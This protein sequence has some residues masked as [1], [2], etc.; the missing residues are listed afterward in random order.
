[1]I[2]S[3]YHNKKTYEDQKT[4][5]VFET[6]L[7][8][9]DELFWGVLRSACFDNDNLP[10]VAGQIEDYEFWPHW[11]PT[12][13]TNSTLVEPDVFIQFQSFDLIIEAKYG[14]QGG[15]YY[16]QWENEI[17]AYRNEYGDEKPVYFL[18]VGGNAD[19]ASAS[20]KVRKNVIVNKCTWL[21]LLIQITRLRDEY[22]A[23]SMISNTHSAVIRLL[24]LIELAFNVH[25][26]YNI[27]WF[28][29]IATSKPSFHPIQYRRL[30][31][32]SNEQGTG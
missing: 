3:K 16:Q 4:S 25:G 21:S 6:M 31:P 23:L 19:K 20:V 28:D 10:Q 26:V 5:S 32:I 27:R 15:Q 7:M 18:A 30:K 13:T 24:N 14:E 9:P 29:E 11:D 17:I 2:H 12:G 1:M 8:L 22:D